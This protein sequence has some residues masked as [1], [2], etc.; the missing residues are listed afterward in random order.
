MAA[1]V[2]YHSNRHLA[3]AKPLEEYDGFYPPYNDW[4]M[5]MI[6]KFM[7][8]NFLRQNVNQG[9]RGTMEDLVCTHPWVWAAGEDDADSFESDTVWPAWA[10]QLD[11]MIM[12]NFG[13]KVLKPLLSVS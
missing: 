4:F 7:P 1:A 13:L 12:V 8:F 2:E 9:S 5:A 11:C 6:H 3:D 10:A